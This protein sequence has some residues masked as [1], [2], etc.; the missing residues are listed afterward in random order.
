[1][2]RLLGSPAI[3][4]AQSLI[5][6][7]ASGITVNDAPALAAAMAVLAAITLAGALASARRR[8]AA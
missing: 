4:G 5:F 3:R 7:W 1:M 2:M 8:R 6:A